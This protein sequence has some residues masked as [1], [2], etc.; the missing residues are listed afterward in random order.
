LL[1]RYADCQALE[2][3]VDTTLAELETVRKRHASATAKEFAAV[4]HALE[5]PRSVA[6]LALRSGKP[7]HARTLLENQWAKDRFGN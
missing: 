1:T 4:A 2:R 3:D 5:I 7:A 6:L